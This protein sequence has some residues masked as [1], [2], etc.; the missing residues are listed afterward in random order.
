MEPSLRPEQAGAAIAEEARFG[1]AFLRRHGLRLLLLFIGVLL[2]MWAFAELADELHEGE[3]F[4]F[5]DPLLH[6]AH[7]MANAG[8]DR[9]FLLF[10]ALGYLWGV[11]P[12]DVAFVLWLA[13][14]RRYRSSLFA[15]L[16][17][18]GSALLNL[19]TKPVFARDRPS[20]WQSIAPESNYSFPSGHAMGSMTLACV[21]VL[22]AWP[23]RWRWPFIAASAVFVPMV[24]LSRIY[25]G[26]HYPSDILAGWAAAAAWVA[27]CFL[28]VFRRDGDM[29]VVAFIARIR[30]TRISIRV[31]RREDPPPT[32]GRR[33]NEPD[34][35]ANPD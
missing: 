28:L 22:L 27:C 16:S 21:C 31:W 35:P 1:A 2:P 12:F 3:V 17:F 18:V 8:F 4:F 11:V 13:I 24:G 10:S 19:G 20:L 30:T 15:A 23:T 5:D 34:P 9:T 32:P 7:G 33:E 14:K 29:S 26:V 25:L 6:F